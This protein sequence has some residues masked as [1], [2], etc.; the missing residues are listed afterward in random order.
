MGERTKNDALFADFAAVGKGLGTRNGWS[1]A[2]TSLG[3]PRRYR[4]SMIGTQG[5]TL[6]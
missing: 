5:R 4:R 2:D 1:S 6:R 3:R